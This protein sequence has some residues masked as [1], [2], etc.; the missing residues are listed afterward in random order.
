MP[1]MWVVGGASR[2]GRVSGRG[3]ADGLQRHGTQQKTWYGGP[4][5]DK[6]G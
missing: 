4:H 6:I 5:R 1:K 3:L 2:L